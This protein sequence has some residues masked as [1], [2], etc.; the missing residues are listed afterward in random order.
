M[1][2]KLH[3]IVDPLCGWCYAASPLLKSIGQYFGDDLA[4]RFHPGLL[5]ASPANIDPAYRDHIVAADQRIAAL[6]GMTFGEAYLNRVKT[7]DP[8]QYHSVPPAAA[9]MAVQELAPRLAHAMLEQIQKAHYVHGKDVSNVALLATLAEQLGITPTTFASHYAQ[10]LTSLPQHVN[11][12]RA[13]LNA[14]GASGFPNFILEAGGIKTHLNHSHAYQHPER[15]L[16]Q[17][18]TILKHPG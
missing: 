14:F 2:I 4:I 6:A 5:F 11:T 17:I 10:A 1:T 18:D 15:L 12:A 13:Y 16:A 8:L 9:V 7:A 3:A